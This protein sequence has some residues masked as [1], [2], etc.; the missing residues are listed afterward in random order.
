MNSTYRMSAAEVWVMINH[1]DLH[2][3]IST[4]YHVIDIPSHEY[5]GYP[6]YPE[7]YQ[8]GGVVQHDQYVLVYLMKLLFCWCLAI[9]P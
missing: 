7:P 2:D 9:L 4:P 3:N 1:E 8:G 6:G 5:T